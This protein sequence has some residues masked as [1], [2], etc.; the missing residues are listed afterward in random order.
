MLLFA[1]SNKGKIKE[2]K[3]ILN[4]NI[5]SLNDIEKKIKIDENGNTFIENATIKAKKVF[6]QTNIPTIADDSGLEIPSLNNFPGVKTHRFLKGTDNDRNKEILKM[7]ENINDR[8]CYFVCSIAYFNGNNLE[9]FEYR[10]KGTIAKTIKD[11][12]GFGFDSIFLY[13]EKYLSEMTLEEKNNISPRKKAL[14]ML[15]NSKKFQK[16]VDFKN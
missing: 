4:I 6:K 2:V 3:D 9:T 13:K 8:T 16:N 11:G 12:N 15:K 7:M 14:I 1:S 10:L 5:L